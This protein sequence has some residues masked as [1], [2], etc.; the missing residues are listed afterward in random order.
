MAFSNKADVAAAAADAKVVALRAE[1]VAAGK[2]PGT[3]PAPTP[4]LSVAQPTATRIYQRDTRT[5]GLFGKGAGAVAVSVTLSAPV[6]TL[7]FRLRDA[8]AAGNPVRQDW[9]PLGGP[10]PAGPAAL[11]PTVP[12]SP[13][14]YLLDVRAN[15]DTAHAALGTQP[16]GVGEV[17]AV[18]GQS[19]AT[20]M[21]PPC[22]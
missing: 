5:G 8:D 10:L 4:S 14:R 11:F 15:G 6:T 19:L 13:F 9:T 17:V 18:A 16:F 1:L 7:D 21:L 2:L 12:A 22:Q 3:N 20:N